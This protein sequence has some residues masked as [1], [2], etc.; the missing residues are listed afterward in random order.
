MG[1]T[2][3]GHIQ[4][5]LLGPDLT[6]CWYRVHGGDRLYLHGLRL[7]FMLDMHPDHSCAALRASWSASTM[8]KARHKIP[9]DNQEII[10]PENKQILAEILEK[11]PQQPWSLNASEHAMRM[12]QHLRQALAEAFPNNKKRRQPKHVSAETQESYDRI[13]SLRRQ[14]RT[15]HFKRN[16]LWMRFFLWSMG[17]TVTPWWTSCSLAFLATPTTRSTWTW[18]ALGGQNAQRKIEKRQGEFCPWNCAT[19]TGK[20][21]VRDLQVAQ[22]NPTKIKRTW[23]S[24]TPAAHSEEGR[25]LFIL[26]DKWIE[27]F[28]ML[29]TGTSYEPE[30]FVRS[31]LEHQ[32]SRILP[33]EWKVDELPQLGWIEAAVQRLQRGKTPGPDAIVNDVFKSSPAASARLLLPLMRKLCLRLEEPLTAKG[34][35]IIPVY[36]HRG[37]M[38]QCGSYRGIMLLNTYGR[39]MRSCNRSVL[40]QT[41]MNGSQGMQMGGKPGLSVLFGA[42]AL[43]HA[44]NDY[45]HRGVS[46][47]VIFADVES[48]YYMAIRQYAAGALHKDEDLARLVKAFNLDAETMHEIN[49]VLHGDSGLESLGASAYQMALIKETF[50]STWITVTGNEVINTTRGTRPGDN[51]AD[52]VFGVILSKLLDRLLLRLDHEGL[53]PHYNVPAIRSPFDAPLSDKRVCPFHSTWAD[54]LALLVPASKPDRLASNVATAFNALEAEMAAVALKLSLGEHKTA[55]LLLPRGPGSVSVRRR[56]FRGAKATLPILSECQTTHLPLIATY[57]HLGGLVAAKEGMCPELRARAARANAAF[58]KAAKRLYK[59]PEFP[60]ATRMEL[61]RATVLSIW[62]WG[63]GAWPFLSH[64]EYTIFETATWRFYSRLLLRPRGKADE[65]ISHDD[66]Q[67]A[68]GISTPQ[69]MLHETR[70]RHL[71][72]MIACS[73]W[74]W[75]QP[76]HASFVDCFAPSAL[77]GFQCDWTSARSDDLWNW[78]R[79]SFDLG[80]GGNLLASWC[81]ISGNAGCD[82]GFLRVEKPQAHNTLDSRGGEADPAEAWGESESLF[83]A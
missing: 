34:G 6:M 39:I 32:A 48:A 37:A 12:T 72:N 19:S 57:R 63:A 9:F 64:K 53:L 13:T 21:R 41:W 26:D 3:L 8:M 78:K 38:D 7:L 82:A 15:I 11:I 49:A 50:Q 1:K 62:F 54:D 42:Q 35:Q 10:K 24:P 25:H 43:R 27:H 81:W 36:K 4:P 66:I 14:I 44:I 47:G 74:H 59:S 83:F 75:Q 22:T 30:D 29:E 17:C 31:S 16:Q 77:R 52:V 2:T 5:E 65:H 18:S 56:L 69:T 76:A 46:L 45:K 80:S 28:S 58:W 71:G 20:K 61:H 40:L 23:R 51:W 67:L 68:L 73:G 60:L 79:R 70:L 33:G 55:A